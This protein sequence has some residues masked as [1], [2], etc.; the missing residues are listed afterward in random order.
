MAI[1]KE[2]QGKGIGKEVTKQIFEIYKKKGFK[3]FLC[4]V[5]KRGNSIKMLR[6]LGVKESGSDILMEKR[7]R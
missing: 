1:S 5:N 2:F 4:L 6:K 3:R 7:L